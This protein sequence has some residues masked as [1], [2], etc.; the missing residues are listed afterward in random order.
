[1]L[2]SWPQI[3]NRFLERAKAIELAQ[4]DDDNGDHSEP[5]CPKCGDRMYASVR[6]IMVAY[7]IS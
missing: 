5:V 7:D 2:T 3:K 4:D 6:L 1:M